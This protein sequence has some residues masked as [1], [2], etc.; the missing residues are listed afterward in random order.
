MVYFPAVSRLLAIENSAVAVAEDDDDNDNEG[1]EDEDDENDD[2]G[3]R[4]R[5]VTGHRFGSMYMYILSIL[6]A[7]Y[8]LFWPSD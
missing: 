2:E 5:T 1:G 6:Y 3:R 4:N 7:I 8:S